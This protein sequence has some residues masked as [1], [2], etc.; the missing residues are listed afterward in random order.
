MIAMSPFGYWLDYIILWLLYLGFIVHTIAFFKL[1][2]REKYRRTGLVLG[3]L[4]VFGVM[5]GSIGMIG[6]IYLRFYSVKTEALGLS[7]PARRWFALH[8]SL[9]DVG[10]R[11]KQWTREKKAARRI[12]FIGD[13]YTYGWGIIDPADRFSDLIGKKFSSEG[14]NSV[15]V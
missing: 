6:E 3:N 5:L 2:P 4:M 10:C 15:E 14:S 9:N 1:F 7:L 13:S 8:T 11:D 12:A